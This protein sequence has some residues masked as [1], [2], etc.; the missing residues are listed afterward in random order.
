LIDRTR[1]H[2]Q[3]HTDVA[4]FEWKT[5]GHDLPA[6]LAERLQRHGLIPAERETVMIGEAHLL[7]QDVPLPHGVTLRRIGFDEQGLSQPTDAVRA[8]LVR[9]LAMQEA[10]FGSPGHTPVDHLLGRVLQ[11]HGELEVWAAEADGAVICAGRLERVPG[12]DFA[13]IWGGAAVPE[14]RGQGI[15]RALTASRARSALAMGALYIQSDCT[16]FSRPILERS[17]LQ[18]VTTTTPYVWT[19]PI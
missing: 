7:A 3:Q 19:R 8:D 18:A 4:E 11:N 15:Y 13:G 5:R 10:V 2:F 16:E 17:G 12:T 1:S 14:W 9:V 6:D